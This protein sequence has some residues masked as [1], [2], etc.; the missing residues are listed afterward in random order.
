VN[1]SLENPVEQR[2]AL[3]ALADGIIPPDSTDAGASVVHAGERLSEKIS[4]GVNRTVYLDGLATGAAIANE[5]YSRT[6]ASLNP[7]EIHELLG[8]IR[9]RCP[10]FFKQLR[11]DVS[12]AYLSDARVLERIGFPGASA[13]KGGYPDFDQPQ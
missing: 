5:K 10:A 11:M 3:A 4:A 9:E 13:E 8:L 2:L 1:H 12:A 6:I 7:V